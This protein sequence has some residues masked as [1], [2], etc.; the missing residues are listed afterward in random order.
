MEKPVDGADEGFAVTSSFSD[1]IG[2]VIHL[3][4]KDNKAL[5]SIG[6]IERCKRRRPLEFTT[7]YFRLSN[8]IIHN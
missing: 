1:K 5:I 8:V 7:N 3:C 4:F 6:L 2:V